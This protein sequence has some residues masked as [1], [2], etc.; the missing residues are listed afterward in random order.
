[1]GIRSVNNRLTRAGWV[2]G[3]PGGRRRGFTLIELL[4]VVA[5]LAILA[6]LLLPG[7]TSAI[8]RARETTCMSNQRQIGVALF[9]YAGGNDGLLPSVASAGAGGSY[10]GDQS[11]LLDA[12]RDTLPRASTVW[13]CPVSA[14]KEGI[15]LAQYR[16]QNLIGYFYWGWSID[17]GLPKA[18]NA[19][20]P[21]NIWLIQG[22]NTNLVPLVLV[23]DHFRD[24]NF[25]SQPED[26]QYHGGGSV[27][28]ALNRIGTLAVMSDG[29]VKKIAP[30]P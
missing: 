20:A 8:D 27:E 28:Q 15:D 30:R 26:W 14:R 25:W 2:A 7:I 10:Y 23:T 3:A 5:I 9:V 11:V 13:F 6:A 21:E 19:G 12:L 1:M 4:V 22:W 24:K 29:S 17:Q 16:T 18:I